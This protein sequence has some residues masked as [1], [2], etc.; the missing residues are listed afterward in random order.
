MYQELNSIPK[1]YLNGEIKKYSIYRV[2]DLEAIM[3]KLKQGETIEIE[4]VHR[5]TLQKLLARLIC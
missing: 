3:N 5:G 2:L 1:T 4:F